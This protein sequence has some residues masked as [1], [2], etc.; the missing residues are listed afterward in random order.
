MC[1]NQIAYKKA[2]LDIIWGTLFH[3]WHWLSVC[4]RSLAPVKRG[5]AEEAPKVPQWHGEPPSEPYWEE[6]SHAQQAAAWLG[7]VVLLIVEDSGHLERFL[8]T[9][10]LDC[11]PPQRPP[12]MAAWSRGHVLLGHTETKGGDGSP[13]RG[14]ATTHTPTWENCSPGPR[15]PGGGRPH[16]S[17]PVFSSPPAHSVHFPSGKRSTLACA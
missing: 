13:W 3:P 12:P 17:L 16:A 9:P 10:R 15:A 8:S 7:L 2:L 5:A 4:P 11:H 1:P 14:K 6:P